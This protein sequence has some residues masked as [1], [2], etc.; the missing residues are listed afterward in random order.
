MT[1]LSTILKSLAKIAAVSSILAPVAAFALTPDL[2]PEQKDR[3]R[4]DKVPEAVAAIPKDYKFVQDG[5]LTVATVPWQLPLVDYA[6]DTKTPIGNETDIAQIIADSL[7]LKLD[8]HP[9]AWPD[10]PLG[11]TSGKFDAVISNVTVTEERKEKFDFSTY[12]QDVLGFYVKKDS[13]IK[14]I[15]EPKDVAGLKVIVGSGTNQEQILLNW[16]KQNKDAGLADT[17][18]QYYDD[19]AVRHLAIESGR[20]DADL[21]PNS[22]EAFLAEQNGKTRLVGLVN[23][24]WPLTAEIAVATKKGSGLADAI[25]AALNAQI[26]NG[27]YGKVLA[28]WGLT[29]EGIESS[30]TNPPGLPKS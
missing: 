20:A 7:G 13:P 26:K 3:V 11:L 2:S 24:G 4:A 1:K 28:R 25:T 21:E 8:L 30:R 27:N 19:Q 29:S 6:S 16:V 12:R 22:A 14:S 15:T 17:E 10:W 5:V 23:G 9:I 18:I